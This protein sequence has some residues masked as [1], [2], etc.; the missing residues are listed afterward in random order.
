MRSR[1]A[2][3]KRRRRRRPSRSRLALVSLAIVVALGGVSIGVFEAVAH[4]GHHGETIV[5]S[6][7]TTAYSLSLRD[8]DH[9]PDHQ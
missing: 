5:I 1:I 7:E 4:L 9:F 8:N 6:D 3:E 2:E